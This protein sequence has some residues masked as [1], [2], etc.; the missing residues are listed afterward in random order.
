MDEI[1][2]LHFYQAGGKDIKKHEKRLWDISD[3]EYSEFQRLTSE[4]EE[5]QIGLRAIRAR[6]GLPV[7]TEEAIK[8][9]GVSQ[10]DEGI[11]RL[12]REIEKLAEDCGVSRDRWRDAMYELTVTGN[13]VR[14]FNMGKIAYPMIEMSYEDSGRPVMRVK[15][16]SD[17]PIDNPIWFA[18][19]MHWKEL[20]RDMPPKPQPTKE[21][22][23]KKDW[24]PVL[25]WSKRHPEITHEELAQMLGIKNRVTVTRKLSEF[26]DGK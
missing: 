13:V 8:R 23:R 17:T 15:I 24:R 18:Q 3:A 12:G 22:K 25:E 5:L 20:M 7:K 2:F 14:Y 6:Y 4:N 16:Y 9:W 1:D 10:G 11:R 19:L 21:N 26:D